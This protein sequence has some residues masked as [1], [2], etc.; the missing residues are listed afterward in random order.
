MSPS[1]TDYQVKCDP[2]LNDKREQIIEINQR[3]S[4]TIP[5]TI[6]RKLLAFNLFILFAR[7]NSTKTFVPF[8]LQIFINPRR[9]LFL[10]GNRGRIMKI[11]E[12]SCYRDVSVINPVK[13]R[14]IHTER[15]LP[16]E[17]ER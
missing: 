17:R 1:P 3:S 15:F 12:S 13:Q 10:V 6:Y 5:L 11:R 14:R 7:N 9:H 4:S 2:N 16:S 8:E